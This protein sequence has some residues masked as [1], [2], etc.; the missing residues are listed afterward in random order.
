M[1]LSER[2][3]RTLLEVSR[4]GFRYERTEAAADEPVAQRRPRPLPASQA[5]QV[6]S[7]D[8]VFDACDNG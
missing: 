7:Y 1:V 5:N 6:G 2:R 8:F 3:A 4:S